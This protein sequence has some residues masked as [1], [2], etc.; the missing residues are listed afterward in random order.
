MSCK[1]LNGGGGEGGRV[2]GGEDM[3]LEEE[4][5]RKIS[6]SLRDKKMLWHEHDQNTL[7]IHMKCQ[8]ETI[9]VQ[10]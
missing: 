9:L 10:N 3:I 7:H 8:D 2:W 1:W 6:G 5:A 4:L